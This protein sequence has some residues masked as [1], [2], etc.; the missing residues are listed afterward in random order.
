ML[1]FLDLNF[2]SPFEIYFSFNTEEIVKKRSSW[3]AS[4]LNVTSKSK[5]EPKLDTGRFIDSSYDLEL[6][7]NGK[8][9]KYELDLI[10]QSTAFLSQIRSYSR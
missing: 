10:D 3:I 1:I 2:K 5:G 6:F 9:Y 4:S 8:N 7:I